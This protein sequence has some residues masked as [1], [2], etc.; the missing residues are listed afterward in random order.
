MKRCPSCQ[1]TYDDAQYYCFDDATPLVSE[2]P[3]GLAK[4]MVVSPPPPRPADNIP[5]TQIINQPPPM[6]G[7]NQPA[8]QSWQPSAPQQQPA[9]GAQSWGGGYQQAQP[10]QGAGTYGGAYS[11]QAGESQTRSLISLIAG[12]FSLFIA[13]LVSLSILRGRYYVLF[14]AQP[15]AV[16]AITLGVVSLV[17][18][19]GKGRVLAIIGVVTGGLAFLLALVHLSGRYYY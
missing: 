11:Q 5:P 7:Y 1:R 2:P 13:A 10:S 14:I 19:K 8:Q 18:M 17:S 16:A 9:Y 6:Q 15:A 3:Q 12:A 4:T